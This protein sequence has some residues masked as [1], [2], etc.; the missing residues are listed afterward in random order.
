MAR[1]LHRIG[2]WRA[3]HLQ[4]TIQITPTTRLPE[5]SRRPLPRTS[6]DAPGSEDNGGKLH[7]AFIAGY[8]WIAW[9]SLRMN[10]YEGSFGRRAIS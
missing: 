2:H 7:F 1:L 6:R 8:G 10:K 9:V 3:K 4:T 5:V